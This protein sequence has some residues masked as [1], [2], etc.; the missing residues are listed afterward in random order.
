MSLEQ[1]NDDLKL[2]DKEHKVSMIINFYHS[3]KFFMDAKKVDTCSLF[4]YDDDM[5]GEPFD[6]REAFLIEYKNSKGSKTTK[7]FNV[8]MDDVGLTHIKID[9]IAPCFQIQDFLKTVKAMV[10]EKEQTLDTFMDKF[11]LPGYTK[12]YLAQ[13]LDEDLLV[14][15]NKSIK[16]KI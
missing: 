9:Y 15:T 3:V 14:K 4:L 2:L 12:I 7:D 13:K 6:E 11:V 5:F 8:A 16:T 1:I 10:V